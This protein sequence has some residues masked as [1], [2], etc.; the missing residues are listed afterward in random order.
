MVKP[1]LPKRGD[2]GHSA[3]PKRELA[4]E[5]SAFILPADIG[6]KRRVSEAIGKMLSDSR[7]GNLF[8]T[9]W[10][11]GVKLDPFSNEGPGPGGL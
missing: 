11:H 2:V 5:L 7:L 10:K 8:F 9:V 4:K 1:D 6:V 3:N